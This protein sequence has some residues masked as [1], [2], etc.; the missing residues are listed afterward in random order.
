MKKL[1]N[2][3]NV[4]MIVLLLLIIQPFL[5]IYWLYNNSFFMSPSTIIRLLIFFILFVMFILDKKKY[6]GFVIISSVFLIYSLIHHVLASNTDLYW[7]ETYS[8]IGEMF[9]LMRL[10]VPIYFIYFLSFYKI[11]EKTIEKG[12]YIAAYIFAAIMLVTNILMIALPAYPYSDGIDG[13]IVNWFSAR[14]NDLSFESLATK[15]IF[16]MANQI[17]G[18]LILI[19]PVL[20]YYLYRKISVTKVIGIVFIII[21]M[22]MLG[23]RVAAWG[24]FIILALMLCIYIVLCVLDKEKFSNKL[25]IANSFIL[26]FAF[27]LFMFSPIQLRSSLDR[28][29]SNELNSL[30]IQIEAYLKIKNANGFAEKRVE[31][32]NFI[33]DVSWEFSVPEEFLS[34]Y[35]PE[36]DPEFWLEYFEYTSYKKSG[37]YRVIKTAIQGAV[38]NK[39]GNWKTHLFG[40]SYTATFDNGM[41]SE[42]DI[43]A[44]FLYIGII[45]LLIFI[46]PFIGIIL[47]GIYKVLV[48]KRLFNFENLTYIL[49]LGLTICVS[50]FSGHMIDIFVVTIPFAI[51]AS[52]LINNLKGDVDAKS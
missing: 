5:E 12:F 36:E 44:Q 39:Y 31:I 45:G 25:I 40:F 21:S 43:H 8:F 37:N 13:S 18:F 19:F 46:G 51:I 11:E 42:R 1:A 47:Y 32:V 33:R 26:I 48:D 22:L 52:L 35:L 17:S 7:S 50:V 34:I 24:M 3:Q 9:Y 15:G 20:V 14:A 10:A 27:T 28:A 23:T 6:K 4:N 16:N 2:E 41:Y 49:A 29:P 30:K 38:I